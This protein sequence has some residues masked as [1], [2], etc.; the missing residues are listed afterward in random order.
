MA[1]ENDVDLGV[2]ALTQLLTLRDEA[3]TAL[4]DWSASRRE[5]DARIEAEGAER[6]R[7]WQAAN[8]VGHPTAARSQQIAMMPPSRKRDAAM[9]KHRSANVALAEERRAA[10]AA[11]ISWQTFERDERYRVL[12]KRE[13]VF[14]NR[15]AAIQRAIAEKTPPP[16]P[17]PNPAPGTP[18]RAELKDYTPPAVVL[19]DCGS[20]RGYTG[21]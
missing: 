19:A 2:C 3:R 13:K 17:T 14:V 9:R 11:W 7:A 20:V 6:R 10:D 18:W 5:A 4:G 12:A 1:D 15:V 21:D 8:S 16:P